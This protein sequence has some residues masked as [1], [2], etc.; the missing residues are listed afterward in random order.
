MRPLMIAGCLL[1]LF[2]SGCAS[3][4][5]TS[6]S[7]TAA[8]SRATTGYRIAYTATVAESAGRG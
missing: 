5:D 7:P 6:A 2:L 8:G 3:R 1:L 4:K